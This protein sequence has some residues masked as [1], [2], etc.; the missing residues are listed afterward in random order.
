[1]EWHEQMNAEYEA[2]TDDE[3]RLKVLEK[4]MSHDKALKAL[5]ALKAEATSGVRDESESKPRGKK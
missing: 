4:H 5:A 3:G 1:M 2:A